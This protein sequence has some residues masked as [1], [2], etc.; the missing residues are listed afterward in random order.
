MKLPSVAVAFF[1]FILIVILLYLIYKKTKSVQFLEDKCAELRE[2]L[3]LEKEKHTEYLSFAK[4]FK[5]RQ[6]ISKHD[7]HGIKFSIRSST[8]KNLGGEFFSLIPLLK[9][10]DRCRSCNEPCA[11]FV[12]YLAKHEGGFIIGDINLK[13]IPA[14]LMLGQIMLITQQVGNMS[15]S[16][17]RILQRINDYLVDND[18]S[19][20]ELYLTAFC[21]YLDQR[22]GVLRYSI[23]GHEP[24]IYINKKENSISTIHG[25]SMLLGVDSNARFNEAELYLNKGDKL[26]MFTP[27][28]SKLQIQDMQEVIKN[29]IEEDIDTLVKYVERDLQKYI[30]N[31]DYVLV[32]LEVMAS[33][34]GKYIIPADLS[35][36]GKVIEEVEFIALQGK[37]SRTGITA[38]RIS[39]S[40]MMANAII[41]GSQK[42]P[43]KFIEIEVYFNNNEIKVSVK[44]PG[45]GFD[46]ESIVNQSVPEDLMAERGRG[47]FIVK[48]YT[49]SI[50]F[51]EGGSRITITK[52][53]DS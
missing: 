25:D 40:E 8:S 47:L 36:I 28:S 49:D 37:M 42:D 13:D 32:G 48:N 51:S 50:E 27:L 3:D 21:G 24:P 35:M 9:N 11:K 12:C 26:I 5:N 16:P 44:D 15:T 7:I 20:D 53:L 18:N 23:G 17:A 6:L 31:K 38:L 30:E 33:P 14:S 41:H 45:K 34:Y 46:Y 4:K 29:Y 1:L 39:L 10:P 19:F 52:R 43:S 2:Q 22:K